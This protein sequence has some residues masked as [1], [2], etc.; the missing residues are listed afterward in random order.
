MIRSIRFILLLIISSFVIWNC[1]PEGPRACETGDDC[2]SGESCVRRICQKT[3]KPKNQPPI[4]KIEKLSSTRQGFKVILDGKKSRDPDDHKL[5]FAWKWLKRPAQ[6]QSKLE[7][8]KT[9][10]PFFVPDKAGPYQ[11]QLIVTDELGLASTPAT[12]TIDIYGQDQNGDPVAN[13]GV[14][15]IVG[16]NTTVKLDGSSSTDPEQESL[17]YKWT[18]VSIPKGSQAKFSKDDS[19]KP[20][21]QADRVG[22]YTIQLVVND[23]LEDSPPASIIIEAVANIGFIP[24]VKSLEPKEDYQDQVV[25][26][27]LKGKDF[28]K[29]AVVLFN[30]QVLDKKFVE[31]H[32]TT[33]IQT[34]LHLTGLAAKQYPI[35]VRLPNRKESK[36][37]QFTVKAVQI[38]TISALK[39][40][41]YPEGAKFQLTVTGTGFIQS[42]QIRFK[43]TPLITTFKSATELS[44]E[45]NLSN[46]L[47]G[48]HPVA[49]Q[50][51]G[52]RISQVVQFTV[53]KPSPK[54]QI[55][56]L[57]PPKSQPGKKINFSVHGK[58]FMPLA[59]IVFDG[60]PI[61]TKRI[62]LNQLDADPSLDLTQAQYKTYQVWVVNPGNVASD[63]VAFAVEKAPRITISRILPFQLYLDEVNS[64]GI[65]GTGFTQGSSVFI[66][67]NE[68]KGADVSIKSATYI[69]V[70][71]DTTKGQWKAG[72]VQVH[73]QAKSGEKSTTFKVT[74]VHRTPSLIR[75]SPG[76]W[77][78]SCDTELHL[79]GN[80]FLPKSK[81]YLGTQTYSTTATDKRYLLT[82]VDKTH[83]KL[84]LHASQLLA[85]KYF[86][87]VANSP[88][89]RSSRVEWVLNSNTSIPTP[90]IQYVQPPSA[91]AN[92][93]VEV[94][95]EAD[96]STKIYVGL[97]MLLNGK[98]QETGCNG[99]VTC[100]TPRTKLQL[101]GLA[102]GVH[103]LTLRNPCG[104]EGPSF[105]FW[106]L[107][108]KT[109]YISFI[110]PAYSAPGSKVTLTIRGLH[111][112]T[113]TKLYF[114][115]KVLSVD[116]KSDVQLVTKQP[117]DLS[118]AKPGIAKV[119]LDNGFGQKS[120]VIDF[121]ILD[122]QQTLRLNGLTQHEF[123]AGKV[124]KSIQLQ[125][126]SFTK[127]T[128]V[129]LDNKEIPSTYLTTSLLQLTLDLSKHKIGNAFIHAVDGS[130]KSNTLPILLK[131]LKAS[132]LTRIDPLSFQIFS[133][134]KFIYIYGKEFCERTSP[135]SFSCKKNPTVKIIREKDK[136]DITK[137]FKVL[138]AYINPSLGWK[139]AYVYGSLT[140]TNKFPTGSYL[141]RLITPNGAQSNPGKF[142]ITPI[143]PPTITEV[144]PNAIQQDKKVLVRISGTHFQKGVQVRIGLHNISI[145]SFSPTA[146]YVEIDPKNFAQATH[147]LLVTNPDKQRSKT[148]SFTILP[149][150]PPL[151]YSS[152]TK[153][154]LF[155]GQKLA[156]LELFGAFF[157]S[158]ATVQLN[159]KTLPATV[160]S[161]KKITISNFTVPT[162]ANPLLF[163]VIH[164]DKKTSNV[165]TILH[166]GS[167]PF[168]Q[169]LSPNTTTVQGRAI[170]LSLSGYGIS[171]Q[172]QVLVDGKPATVTYRSP[173]GTSLRI[174][175]TPPKAPAQLKIQLKNG[176]S[177]SNVELLSVLGLGD[178][179]ISSLQETG[180]FSGVARY[181][182]H[183]FRIQGGHFTKSSQIHF[184]GKALKTLYYNSSQLGVAEELD[185]TG[186]K[187]GTYPFQ[188]KDGSKSSNISNLYILTGNQRGEFFRITGLR[189]FWARVGGQS[190]LLFGTSY[191]PATL[192]K[193]YSKTYQVVITGPGLPAGGK[194]YPAQYTNTW[195][196]DI[197]FKGWQKGIYNIYLQNSISKEKSGGTGFVLIP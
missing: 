125:G 83:L 63:K 190:K 169:R 35:V 62:S 20:T 66:G 185:L 3:V 90:K 85:G 23:G 166:A 189:T 145:K 9:S 59:T 155:A 78:N 86:V 154:V 84:K 41:A 70:K 158:K 108:P 10:Q 171:A 135:T 34:I 36:P 129:Y 77:F 44:A 75:L 165:H 30:G 159:G 175:V 87:Y 186:L 64:I 74:F 168:I 156:T 8:E 37:V 76:G 32:S 124:Y 17:T 53:L 97:T 96:A 49:V 26:V 136:V 149:A 58:D 119:Y 51:P 131:P 48:Q 150:M 5:T 28:D 106:V 196:A 91:P 29:D 88:A 174:S 13:A 67:N 161:D 152:N 157:H 184:N 12:L 100:Y 147:Q 163:Q 16:V 89:A 112:S 139:H 146:L 107:P 122:K 164:P 31:V 47:A 188:V 60:K 95:F 194:T 4:A 195:S 178:I 25:E 56:N 116:V 121:P 68:L 144:V 101:G 180:V 7:K 148:T 187:K 22:K 33:H 162:S 2:L 183:T 133:G 177:L 118:Q 39:P 82:F 191:A 153:G 94:L 182:I 43:G 110:S 15:Q 79:Y 46:V 1:A 71:V 80:N 117:I 45:V 128:K 176:T 21:F 137:Q 99:N 57:N 27:N 130:K 181:P 73:V 109:P 93:P 40:A 132:L 173:L 72:D 126:L 141:V 127:Q 54:P 11:V 170:T 14:D 81:V 167:T 134:N 61:P 172:T 113:N 138:G 151:I 104:V 105:P 18:F 142:N 120:Q 6:S 38:P 24:E 52:N 69:E 42:S 50:N 55:L 193:H 123:E 111:F 102:P 115:G 143:P 65:Y 103:K 160:S 140:L 192:L 98:P 179:Y 114:N 19:P 92:H 197:S